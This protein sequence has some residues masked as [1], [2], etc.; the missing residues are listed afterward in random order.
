LNTHIELI[1]KESAGYGLAQ[2]V[3][4]PD[5]F[6]GRVYNMGGGPSCRVVYKDYLERMMS[7]YGLG[8]YRK[9][10]PLNW[11]ASRNFHCCWYEDSWVLNQYLGHWRHSL[12]EHYRQAEDAAPWYLKLGAR[13]APSFAV[14]A[15]MKRMADPLK[16]VRNGEEEKVKAFF[17]SRQAWESIP[18]WEDYVAEPAMEPERHGR[19]QQDE[20][21]IDG[22]QGLA[23]SRGGQCLS[24]EF[25]GVKTKLRWRCA[26][27]HEWEATALCVQAGH[28]CPECAPPPWDY[29]AIARVDPLLA[30]FYYN[31]HDENESQKV[32]YLYCPNQ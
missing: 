11:F 14:K 30:G 9:I 4:A 3:E 28:W 2:C 5:E 8:D 12:E 13:M 24:T 1:T 32:D 17:G 22:M 16:W 18:D 27:G 20:D 31:N 6:Y 25:G 29:D 15:F 10:M 21:T 26:F 19:R 7:V 23:Q